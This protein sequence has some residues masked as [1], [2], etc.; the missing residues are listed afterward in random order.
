MR[1]S[2]RGFLAFAVVLAYHIEGPTLADV[3][4]HDELRERGIY[5]M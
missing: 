3:G 4:A 1:A 2:T 5:M